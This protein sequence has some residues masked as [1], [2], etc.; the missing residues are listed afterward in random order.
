[1]P[2]NVRGG[3]PWDRRLVSSP[4]AA[5]SAG[6][7]PGHAQALA[8]AH[9][10]VG[11]TVDALELGDAHAGAARD[12]GERVAA[13]DRDRIV[14]RGVPAAAGVVALRQ[15]Q[16]VELGDLDAVTLRG[17]GRRLADAQ[18]EPLAAMDHGFLEPVP[19][20]E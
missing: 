11:E 5:C 20:H 19:G 14:R 17:H 16:A 1:G 12:R 6:R 8:A 9:L 15:A 13:L 7:T 3:G 10:V 2:I 18:L 4:D